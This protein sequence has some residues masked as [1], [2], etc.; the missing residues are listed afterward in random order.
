MK[1]MKKI[2]DVITIFAI[3][4]MIVL[5][6][7][8]NFS[9]GFFDNVFSRGK[10]WSEMGSSDSDQI[11]ENASSITQATDEIYNT[12]RAIGA[13]LIMVALVVTFITLNMKTKSGKDI[14]GAKL[15]IGFTV[16]LAI[17]FIF[18]KQFMEFIQGILEDFEGLM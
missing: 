16:G 14:A 10:T 13:G 6:F 5:I 7:T 11:I 15:T 17:L 9:Y 12:V 8:I 4:Q 2:F 18:A 1:I 3:L